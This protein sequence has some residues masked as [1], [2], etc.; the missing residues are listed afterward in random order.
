LGERSSW[1][2]DKLS[3]AVDKKTGC[4]VSLK[5]GGEEALAAGCCG[6]QLQAFKDTPKQYDAW[7]IDPGTLDQPR[8]C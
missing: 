8:P 3:L 2:N 6:N 1:S 4:I 5:Q 7:N